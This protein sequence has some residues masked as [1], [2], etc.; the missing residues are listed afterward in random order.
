M[1][2]PV[3]VIPIMEQLGWRAMFFIFGLAGLVWA[4][5]WLWWFRDRPAQHPGITPEE[6]VEL[7]S[8]GS[9]SA[10]THVGI[11]W[12]A[13]LTNRQLWILMAMYAFYVWGAIFFLTWF[14][15]YLEKGRGLSKDELR[16]A[17]AL[18][19]LL[20]A[21]GNLFGG[22]LTD[23]L[24]RR[25]GLTVGRSWMGATCLAVSALLM[26]ATSITPDKLTAVVLL[27]VSF[28]VM[29]CMLP[30]AWA[31]CLDIGGRWSGAVS[32]AMNSAGQAG[33]FVCTVLF[34][35]VVGKA[36]RYD[37][38]LAVIAVMVF[39]SAGIFL[40]VDPTRPLIPGATH[41]RAEEA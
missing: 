21:A 29:D 28:A 34:G 27:A 3:L 17:T 11:P 4:A 26:L 6:L 16:W 39:I 2:A 36:G 31:L 23:I 25:Y 19:F 35:Y 15:E 22:F 32:G 24:S 14:P 8:G 38:A 10:S 5:G 30:T 7:D 20:G 18:P 12:R 13:L 1:L 40:F 9:H 41:A 37:L 33:G